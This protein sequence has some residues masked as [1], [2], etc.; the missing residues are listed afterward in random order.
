MQLNV[1]TLKHIN[2][3]MV[4]RDLLKRERLIVCNP[5]TVIKFNVNFDGNL[6]GLNPD[7]EDVKRMYISAIAN[8]EKELI[9]HGVML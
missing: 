7:P 5:K 1:S 9:E 4:K 6:S 8:V 2:E 3:L